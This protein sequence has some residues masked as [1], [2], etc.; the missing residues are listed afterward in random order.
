[1]GG[2]Q[3]A[4]PKTKSEKTQRILVPDI[5]GSKIPTRKDGEDVFQDW[6]ETLDN[7]V[8]SVQLQL[9]LVLVALREKKEVV[10]NNKI[11]ELLSSTPKFEK[12]MD[13]HAAG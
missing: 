1:M 4:P 13:A 6:R 2:S 12:P 10:D 8:G 9:D 5:Q 11:I 3:A 7:Q